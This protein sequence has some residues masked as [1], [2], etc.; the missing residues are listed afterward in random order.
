MQTL[1]DYLDAELRDKCRPTR[2]EIEDKRHDFAI[3]NI[4]RGYPWRQVNIDS[5]V[6]TWI[7]EETDRRVAEDCYSAGMPK[8]KRRVT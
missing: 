3:Q 7:E 8:L 6:E 1:K 4:T 2:D 5:A